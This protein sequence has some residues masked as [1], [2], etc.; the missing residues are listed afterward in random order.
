[1]QWK[2]NRGIFFLRVK[3]I[4]ML[5]SVVFYRLAVDM[6]LDEFKVGPFA[7]AME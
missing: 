6:S 1:M 3:S 7:S 5:I 4:L 2:G